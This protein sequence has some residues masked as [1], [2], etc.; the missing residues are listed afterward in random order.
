MQQLVALIQSREPIGQDVIGL[1][2]ALSLHNECTSDR[3]KQNAMNGGTI[4]LPW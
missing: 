3:L 2:D 1:M 4:V